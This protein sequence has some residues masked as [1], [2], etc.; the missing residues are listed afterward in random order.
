MVELV[1][2]LYWTMMCGL[3]SIWLVDAGVSRI[4]QSNVHFCNSIYDFLSLLKARYILD[5]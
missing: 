3:L 4:S 1:L 5:I 2:S